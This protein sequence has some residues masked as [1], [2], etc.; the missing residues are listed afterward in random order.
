ME[1]QI[2]LTKEDLDRLERVALGKEWDTT[3]S[4]EGVSGVFGLARLGLWAQEC[5]LPAM[6]YDG[7]DQRDK[8]KE[9]LDEL[10]SDS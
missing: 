4:E 3:L 6:I 5:A 7:T 9:A 8:I 1:K 10:P 2:D